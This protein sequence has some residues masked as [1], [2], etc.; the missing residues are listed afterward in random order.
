MQYVDDAP[1]N[2]SSTYYQASAVAGSI[3]DGVPSFF[4]DNGTQ[5][6]INV[7]WPD[8][9]KEINGSVSALQYAGFNT[10]YGSAAIN[11][12]GMFPNGTSEGKIV[13][14]GFPFETI[15]P[16]ENRNSL[17]DKIID[18]FDVPTSIRNEDSENL[19][20]EFYLSQNYPNPFNPTTKIKFT[21][22]VENENIRSLLKIYD[23]LGN[24]V[25]TLVDEQKSPG[26][27]EVEWNAAVYTSGVYFYS[28]QSGNTKINKKMLLLK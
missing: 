13:A 22:P 7:K 20:T 18:F 16:E 3:F 28:L 9:I 17:M 5:G 15:Y 11:F 6:T 27:Y 10:S 19:P 2:I 12:E 8:V 26:T 21:I 23:L 25:A 1:G 14:M 24:E 4:F